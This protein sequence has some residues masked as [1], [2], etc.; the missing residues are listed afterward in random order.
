MALKGRKATVDE[1]QWMRDVAELG[2]IVCRLYLE[3]Y[4]PAEIHHIDGKTKRGCHYHIIPLCPEHHRH[5]QI[6]PA[7]HKNKTEFERAYGTEQELFHKVTEE[8]RR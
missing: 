3:T 2:C 5:G 1:A 8:V 7:R 4:T 6:G